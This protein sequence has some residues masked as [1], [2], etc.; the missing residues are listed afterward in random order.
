MTASHFSRAVTAVRTDTG[1]WLYTTSAAVG[2]A[3]LL[4]GLL[5]QLLLVSYTFPVSELLTSTALS[6]V[7]NAYHWYSLYMSKYLFAQ[8]SSVIY[9]PNFN[10]GIPFAFSTDPSANPAKL[11]YLM[12]PG[13]VTEIQAWKIYVFGASV[14]GPVLPA[15]G[16][17]I[18][19]FSGLQI[20]VGGVLGL[21]VWWGSWFHYF[22]SHGMVSWVLGCFTAF[23]VLC[24]VFRYR[25]TPGLTAAALVGCV[26]A[27]MIL[28]HPLTIV[29]V[30]FMISAF[31]L[32]NPASMLKLNYIL[33]LA[34][35]TALSVGLNLW[36]ILDRFSPAFD[37]GLSLVSYQARVNPQNM[38]TDLMGIW[39]RHMHGSKTYPLLVLLSIVAIL[40]TTAE[41]R[42]LFIY[43]F[44]VA[45][46]CLQLY[47]ALG[48]AIQSLAILTQPN[49]YAP[50]GYLLLIVPAVMAFG[51]SHGGY[52]SNVSALPGKLSLAIYSMAAL[53]F[54]FCAYELF[55]EVT[56]GKHGRYASAP[57]NVRPLGGYSEFVLSSL[58]AQTNRQAR[59]LFETSKGRIHDGGHL[60]GYYAYKSGREFIGGPY[61]FRYFAG[62]WDGF[63]FGRPITDIPREEFLVYLELYNV[64]WVMAHS[65]VSKQYF[66][67]IEEISH[68]E[69]YRELSFYVVDREH[70]FFAK[71][72]GKVDATAANRIALTDLQGSQVVLKYHYIEGLTATPKTAITPVYLSDD[73]LPFIAL[74]NPVESVTLSLEH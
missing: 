55:R 11:I 58:E 69:S 35:F 68:V 7:D 30:F 17:R 20:A 28:I 6:Y 40:R 65:E 25:N 33:F 29:P 14:I 3:V 44:I 12:L 8:D 57:P 13:S 42:K 72:S 32:C 1:N 60:A 51:P 4:C 48:G 53:V 43:P 10:A 73:P 54:L 39:G 64:G 61:T 27:A 5:F 71:G 37:Q 59:V 74:D 56:Y 45:W 9:D 36:W 38:L 23:F 63:V 50:A 2:N 26:G 66:E 52:S 70:S 47:A 24:L 62:F 22:V 49:R 41:Q 67:S 21:L 19:G 16:L 31:L 18:L 46:A 34:V 15:L